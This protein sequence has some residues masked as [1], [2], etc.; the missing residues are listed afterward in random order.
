MAKRFERMVHSWSS[1][2]HL[3]WLLNNWPPTSPLHWAA[4]LKIESPCCHMK[5]TWGYVSYARGFPGGSDSR[6]F[7]QCGRPGF[8]PWVRKI[9]CRREWLPTPVFLPGEFHG[10]RRLVGNCPRGC[11]ELDTTERVTPSNWKY[12][13][14]NQAI[15]FLG[16]SLRNFL[17][18]KMIFLILIILQHNNHRISMAFKK[19]H[20]WSWWIFRLVDG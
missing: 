5:P 1:A 3:L 19:K 2:S 8:D 7:L 12:I 18:F 16:N 9:P 10:W 15:P 11:K 13:H 20:F 14:C 4:L 6:V 17:S